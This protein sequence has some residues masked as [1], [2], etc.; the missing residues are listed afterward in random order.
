MSA[1]LSLQ[2]TRPAPFLTL[3]L[4]L[5]NYFQQCPDVLI[6]QDPN[7]HLVSESPN[8]LYTAPNFLHHILDGS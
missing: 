6:K 4:M 3:L 2:L 5:T 8:V 1:H 7:I